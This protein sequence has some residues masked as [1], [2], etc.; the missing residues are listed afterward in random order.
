MEVE[1]N[2]KIY[3]VKA[4]V[5]DRAGQERYRAVTGVQLRQADGALVVYDIT[6]RESFEKL[7]HWLSE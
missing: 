3:N 7:Q 2:G 5:W 6:Q 4:K 1:V